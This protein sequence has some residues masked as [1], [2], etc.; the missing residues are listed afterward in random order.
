MVQEWVTE[1]KMLGDKLFAP[2]FG[3]MV[4]A[5]TIRN[6]YPLPIAENIIERVASKEAYSFLDG[7]LSYNQVSIDPKYQHKTFF[8]TE[9]GI[10]TYRVMPFGLTNA[11]ATF[12]Q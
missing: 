4:N 1:R 9:W 12:Q 7:F 2:E 5:A 10:F 6:N 11:S 3:M 8:A